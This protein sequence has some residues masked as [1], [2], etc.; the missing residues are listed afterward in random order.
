MYKFPVRILLNTFLACGLTLLSLQALAQRNLDPTRFEDTIK[1]FEA[2]D[3]LH[4]PPKGAIVLTGSS[5]I[6][7]WNNQAEAALAP[8]TVIPRGFGGSIMADVLH[9]ID[10]VAIGYEPRAILIYEGIRTSLYA[11]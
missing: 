1:G 9:Y 8:L 2:Q 5:S 4:P 3:R 10:R 6:A 7:R 11:L